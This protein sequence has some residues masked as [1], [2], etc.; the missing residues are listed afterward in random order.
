VRRPPV[1]VLTAFA[2]IAAL[3]ALAQVIVELGFTTL[4]GSALAAE[5]GRRFRLDVAPRFASWVGFAKQHKSTPFAQALESEAAEKA[6][7]TLQIVNDAINQRVKWVDDQKHWQ[8]IDYWATPAESVA[9][10][11]GASEDLSI[12][13]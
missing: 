7:E 6:A 10:P 4:A 13:N 3:A 2:C 1:A 9:P 11:G 12:A 8:A 5:Y